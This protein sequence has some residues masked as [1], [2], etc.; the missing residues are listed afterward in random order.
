MGAI[1]LGAHNDNAT[2]I[3]IVSWVRG[4]F[5]RAAWIEHTNKQL[6]LFLSFS[7]HLHNFLP[8]S[9]VSKNHFN[10]TDRYNIITMSMQWL[11]AIKVC[12][13]WHLCV[14]VFIRSFQWWFPAVDVIA[15]TQKLCR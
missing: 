1:L 2:G 15:N 14:C 7:R 11:H 3:M 13:A 9:P 4:A 8:K 5:D 12:V 6:F 10:T